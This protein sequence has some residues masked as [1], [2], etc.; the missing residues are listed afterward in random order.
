MRNIE[1]DFQVYDSDDPK[2][3]IILDTSVWEHISKKPSII[4]IIAPGMKKP[5]VLNYKKN[6]VTILNSHNLRLNC[7]TCGEE[8]YDLP[9]GIYEITI[10]GSPDRFNKK[11]YY[12][13]TTTLQSKLDD[14]LISNY[15]DEC[16]KND[17]ILTTNKVLRYKD[18]IHIAEAFI[19]KGFI[20]DA[21]K[22]INNI[23]D[24]INQEKNCKKCPHKV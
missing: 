6:S 20:S 14:L 3:I 2:K 1:L 5:V 19:R 18:L 7:G 13:K 16:E 11:R 4:E 17:N 24:F 12:L 9:D 8:Y 21:N 10:K 22:I 15:T 23:V